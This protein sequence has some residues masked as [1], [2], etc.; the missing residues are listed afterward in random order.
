[1]EDFYT[2]SHLQDDGCRRAI[3]AFY[4]TERAA[5]ECADTFGLWHDARLCTDAEYAYFVSVGQE[6]YA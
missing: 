2:I 4:G 6:L 5:Q 3:T 1:M